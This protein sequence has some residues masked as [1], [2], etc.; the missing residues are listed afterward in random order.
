MAEICATRGAFGCRVSVY[1]S[2]ANATAIAN[3]NFALRR[4]GGRFRK[5]TVNWLL[6]KGD[7]LFYGQ[8]PYSHF[9]TRANTSHAGQLFGVREKEERKK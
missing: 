5:S 2:G 8:K 3:T 6:V 7:F 1:P 9:E 4:V